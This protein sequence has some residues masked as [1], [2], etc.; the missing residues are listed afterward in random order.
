M[1]KNKISQIPLVLL[2]GGKGI[3]I[4]KNKKFSRINKGLIEIF[5]KPLFLW[6]IDYYQKFG[7][8][9]IILSTGFQHETY[10]RVLEK[11]F[12]KINNYKF[13]NK[14]KSLIIIKKEKVDT[15]TGIRVLNAKKLLGK[16]EDVFV[17]YSDTIADINFLAQYSYHKKKKNLAT[18]VSANLPSRFRIL[19]MNLVNNNIVGFS[20]KLIIKNSLINGG[21]Y[22]FSHKFFSKEIID[23]SCNA[24]ELKPLEKIS[25]I[26]KLGCFMHIGQWQHLDSE[27]DINLIKV[28]IKNS[29]IS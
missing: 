6:I 27:K 9:K 2:C 29:F 22:I 19:N 21:F 25:K 17:H 14:N 7:V 12:T 24:L 23:K 20:K 11:E 28:L 26:N 4:E 10:I 16:F 8:K 5:N 3:L 1:N 15:N 18:L 13:I